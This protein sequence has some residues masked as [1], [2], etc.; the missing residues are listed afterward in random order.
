VH[1]V[2]R[3]DQADSRAPV[4]GRG[5]PGVFELGARV[6]DLRLID[7]QLRLQL[8]DRGALG[9]DGLLAG[10][11]LGLQQRVALEVALRVREL[12]RVLRRP[13]GSGAGRSAPTGRLCAPPGLR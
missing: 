12:S 9:V 4:D 10:E 7:L 2:A 8:V 6:V 5:D 3:V 13:P 1:D 11:I